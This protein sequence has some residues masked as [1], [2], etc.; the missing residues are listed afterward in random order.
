MIGKLYNNIGICSLGIIATLQHNDYLPVTK[1][2]L[3]MPIIAHSDLT[4][5]LA[6][7]TTEVM[8]VEHIVS[9]RP[10]FFSNFNDRFYDGMVASINSLQLLTEITAIDWCDGNFSVSEK[11]YYEKT[12][13]D[14]AKKIFDASAN[15]SNLLK[16]DVKNLYTNLRVQI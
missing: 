14:R 12:M 7:S 4:S 6:R 8:S 15:I 2:L 5:Y 10:Q 11:I 16:D 9:K 1:I 13:G 3:I